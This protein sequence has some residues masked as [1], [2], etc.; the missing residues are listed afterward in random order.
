M[1]LGLSSCGGELGSKSTTEVLP[2]IT[3][4]GAPLPS[5]L[6]LE[7]GVA[8]A[9][10]SIDLGVGESLVSSVRVRNLNLV[11]L[12][13]SDT[14]ALDDGAEDSFD[15]LSELDV[16]IRANFG[17]ETREMLIATLPEGDLQLGTA[18]RNLT[19][20]IVN[21][22]A[23]LLDFILA[24]GGYDVVLRLEGLIPADTVLIGGTIR[25]RAGIGF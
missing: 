12:D 21:S 16:S 22:R 18:A 23:D 8:I 1:G 5:A 7:L 25:F 19:L 2:L 13:A 11:I 15:F 20:T 14:D 17:N 9:Q 3:V 10:P 4:P 24:P 6:R